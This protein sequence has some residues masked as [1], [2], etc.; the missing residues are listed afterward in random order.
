[1]DLIEIAPTANP[2]VCKIMNFGKYKYQIAKK[3][4]EAKKK[5]HTIKLKEIKMRPITDTHD[6]HYKMEHAREFLQDGD[7]VKLTVVFRG[8]EMA[9]QEFG[10]DIVD[11]MRKDLED[12]AMVEIGSRME[13]KRMTTIFM[14]LPKSKMHKPKEGA[15]LHPIAPGAAKEAAPVKSQEEP[16]APP[17]QG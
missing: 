14:P 13:G 12:I 11:R 8:R 6:Y 15:P 17:A 16:P 7:K 5:Q 9:H 2:P 10:H 4:K 1:M 3:A